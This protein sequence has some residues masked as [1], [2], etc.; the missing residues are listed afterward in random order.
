LSASTLN[1]IFAKKDEIREQIEKCG[2]ACK[3][4][5]TGRESTF[6]ELETVLFAWYQQ[7]RASNIPIDGTTLREKAKIIAAQLNIHNFSASNGWVSRFK[8]R[9]GLV[10]KKLVGESAEVSAEST[11]AWLE[12]LSSL[13]EGYE[14]RDVYNA[15]E[16]GLFFNVL[17]DRTLAYKGES[18]H[19]GKHSKDRLTVLLC[20]NS[21]GSDKHLPIVIGKS[22]KPRCFKNVKKLPTKYH[23]NGKAWMTTEIFC[24]F[25]HTLDAQM[26]AQN[27]QIILFVDNC[28]AHPKDTS[29]LRNVKVVRYP[30]NCTSTLQPLDLGI[31]HSLKA[32]YRKRLV[33]TYICRMESGKEV[34]KKINVFEA[35]HYIIAAWRQVSQQ[36]IQNCFR[37]AGHKYQ[38]DGNE[39]ANGDDDN[40]DSFGQDWEE[41]CRGQKYDFQS[42]VSVDRHVATSGVETVEELCEA[43]RST[44]SVEEEDKEEENE[45]EMVPSFA[46]TYEALQKFKAFFYAQSGSDADHG[47]ILGLEKS[48]F[49]LRQ[50]S[51]KKQIIMCDFFVKK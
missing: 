4:R 2:N 49:Q 5:K 7:A 47:H 23:A 38:S 31:I 9:H 39:M 51:A 34:K 13:L 29:F 22:P 6:A 18:C 41:L 17:P 3:K 48:Y 27:R 26:G 10:F 30:A 32:Y 28:A 24:S 25:L 35:M 15:D 44:R 46:E 8:D 50:N 20:V 42:Y 37:K 1:S 33:Q 12:S 19:G 16:T 11:D 40:D 14:P 45:Q 21:D 36:T 43:F